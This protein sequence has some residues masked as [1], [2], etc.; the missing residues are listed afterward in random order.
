[1]NYSCAVVGFC[2]GATFSDGELAMSYKD[3]AEPDSSDVRRMRSEAS[4]MFT[5]DEIRKYLKKWTSLD[6]AYCYIDDEKAGIKAM[7]RK[8]S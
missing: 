6:K 4:D 5:I 2:H 1:M 7:R 3:S 8:K